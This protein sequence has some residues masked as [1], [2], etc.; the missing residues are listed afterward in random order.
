MKKNKKYILLMLFVLRIFV[1]IISVYFKKPLS[2]TILNIIDIIL[3]V[4]SIEHIITTRNIYTKKIYYYLKIFM[5]VIYMFS[6]EYFISKVYYYRYPLGYCYYTEMCPKTMNLYYQGDNYGIFIYE[7]SI[8]DVKK[9]NNKWKYNG[10]TNAI[11][12]Y[13]DY[14]LDIKVF[15]IENN[16]FV[17][18]ILNDIDIK[19]ITD[20]SNTDFKNMTTSNYE[21]YNIKNRYGKLIDSIENYKIYF[22][23]EEISLIN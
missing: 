14:N 22:N 21:N 19:N 17:S 15:E 9:Y 10:Y 2:K 4:L 1:G 11:Y 16:Y 8:I 3:G 18:L 7:D 23:N 13:S 5:A 20:N 6:F 12:K